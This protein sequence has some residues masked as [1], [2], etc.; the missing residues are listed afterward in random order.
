MQP[1]RELPPELSE[2]PPVV[3]KP[4]WPRPVALRAALERLQEHSATRDWAV[5]VL[6]RLTELEHGDELPPE[7]F[8]RAMSELEAAAKEAGGIHGSLDLRQPELGSEV[9]RIEYAIARRI[10]VWRALYSLARPR[11]E[12]AGESY[13]ADTSVAAVVGEPTRRHGTSLD[14]GR[15]LEEL[16]EYEESRPSSVGHSIMTAARRL[17]ESNEPA[18]RELG[19]QLASHYR[20]ANLRLSVSGVML[21]RLL[22]QPKPYVSDVSETVIG[23]PVQGHRWTETNL[24]VRLL[25]DDRRIRLGL[26]AHGDVVSST[27]ATSGPAT[28]FT[29][30]QSSFVARK[31]LLFDGLV[32]R[33]YPAVASAESETMLS[34]IRTDF[35]RVPFF[36]SFVQSIARSRYDERHEEALAEVE[37]KVSWHA[38]EELQRQAG[39]KLARLAAGWQEHIIRPLNRFELHPT[40]ISQTTDEERITMRYRIAGDHQLGGHTSRPRAPGDSLVS[41]QIHESTINNAIENFA[42]AGRTFE[43][44][45]LYD[46]LAQR[47]GQPDLKAPDDVPD[48]VQ[49]TFDEKDCLHVRFDKGRVQIELRI[50]ELVSN[51]KRWQNLVIRAGYQPT[52]AGLDAQLRRIEAVQVA[53]DRLSTRS[54]VTL[55]A[56]FS[57]M[58]TRN[59]QV[60]L[61]PETIARDSRLTDLH[62]SQLVIEDGWLGLAVGINRVAAKPAAGGSRPAVK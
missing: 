13:V 19:R 44:R 18:E 54:Q 31:L 9:L 57:R 61:T 56:I 41:L 25:P 27:Q 5:R 2:P 17:A 50:K 28:V 33:Q 22:T 16:E 7:E 32:L 23:Y 11:R 51:E 37:Q 47:L 14:A 8:S 52:A 49:V 15:F 20:N 46:R 58:F 3:K 45:S 62:V 38:S 26:E 4:A 36:G 30:G 12:A 48:H 53:G 29:A 40:P 39:P 34:G 1:E 6:D 24:R 43:L 42:L 60:R 59:R 35:D 21:N 55:K 10:D